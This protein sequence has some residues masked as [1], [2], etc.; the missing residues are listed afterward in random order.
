MGQ[1][2]GLIMGG[3]GAVIG[4]YFGG[5]MGAEAG[6]M[7][8]SMLGGILFP[9][10]KPNPADV[11]VQDS[12]Y[13]KYIPQVWGRYRVAGNMIWAGTPHAQNTSGKGGSS[14]TSGAYTKMSF[15][16]ALCEGPVD[17]VLRI[18]ANGKLIYDVSNPS[19]WQS[20]SGSSSMI[21]GWTFYSGGETQTADPIMES[22]LGVGNVPAFRGLCYVVFNELNLQQWGNY[23][24]SLSFEV[25]RDTTTQ[26]IV[27]GQQS[28]GTVVGII[29]NTVYGTQILGDGTSYGW[30]TGLD[31]YSNG[32][33]IRP[34]YLTSYGVQW[35]GPAFGVGLGAPCAG[36]CLSYD[37]PGLY[38][39]SGI[40]YANNGDVLYTGLQLG[41]FYSTGA[42]AVKRGG[43][44]YVTTSYGGAAYPLWIA[45][46]TPVKGGLA[47]YQSS[48][49]Q[50]CMSVIG[51]SDSYVYCA[52]A[53]FD[54]TAPN[55]IIYF[56]LTGDY[57]G[58][59][60]SGHGGLGT[61]A[62][63]VSDDEI[64]FQF[65]SGG[66]IQLWNGTSLTDIGIPQ[67]FGAN[68]CN[69]K[70]MNQ[71]VAMVSNYASGYAFAALLLGNI[72]DSPTLAEVVQEV[73][74]DA[75]L[76]T[77][78]FDVTQLT[79]AVVGY[80]STNN[81]S[82]RDILSPLLSTFFIDVSDSDGQLKFVRRGATPTVVIP[83]DDLGAAQEQ[84]GADA[85]NPIQE[86]ISQEV[87]LPA[88]EA[89]SYISST[90]DY[91]TSTQREFMPGTASN[92]I[93]STNVPVVLADN[94]AKVRVQ[95]MLWERWSKQRTFKF[96]TGYKYLAYE[97]G[98]V[99]L[100]QRN[101]L[102]TVP[103]RVTKTQFDGKGAMTWEA[104]FTVPQ[105]Y[106]NPSTQT[107]TAQGQSSTGFRQQS[108]DY[109][110]PTILVPM[111]LPPLRPQDA[112]TPAVYLAAGGFEDNWPGARIDISRDDQNFSDILNMSTASIIGQTTGILGTF[113]GGDIPDELNSINVQLY[114]AS[115]SLS[116]VSYASFLNGANVALIGTELV[117]FRNAVQQTDG[118]WTLSGL[119]RGRLDT[120]YNTTH[121]AG[122]VF[123]VL[124]EDAQQIV[125]LN[126][127]DVGNTIWLE[128]YLQNILGTTP[129]VPVSVKPTN[130]RLA[131]FRP[132]QLTALSGQYN[133]GG[134]ASDKT[135]AWFRRARINNGWYDGVDVPLDWQQESYK[136]VIST[137]AGVVVNTYT[138]AAAGVSWTGG[139][140]AGVTNP[141][142]N[143]VQ[144]GNAGISNGQTLP[145]FG[146]TPPFFI[147][148]STRRT[149]DG[150]FTGTTY[151]VSVSQIGDYGV[152]GHVSTTTF[153]Q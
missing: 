105:I 151:T 47:P 141:P 36:G 80:G 129:S 42:R 8:G 139:A 106:P 15:A 55:S 89:L 62:D 134:S 90:T 130:A 58:V 113:N 18:W 9:Q 131:P 19:D 52:T 143:N 73:C 88:Q 96:A 74:E 23:L 64:Y 33:A 32:Y 107:Y 81:S 70:M 53:S 72:N 109:S 16:V 112:T 65:N 40:W 138:L 98:D 46:M 41:L 4:G 29:N 95:A 44:M 97:P 34:Y 125:N 122:E 142:A 7:I 94:D 150:L 146:T 92:L 63:V 75:G 38:L 144:P 5:P 116:S 123:V 145:L 118:S 87:D 86:T 110:G 37:E 51:V 30:A 45:Q 102:T 84:D 13:G 137:S 12:A 127:S 6:F 101:D 148:T 149:A 85:L 114:D 21:T 10:K 78:Q 152:A 128:A 77:S 43:I 115:Q 71:Q 2:A 35:Q 120:L 93:E 147:Y 99:V 49:Q 22:Q 48:T 133:S 60:I 26:A 25:A 108:I 27:T 61:V 20:I 79:D 117:Y 66:N 28:I 76:T 140:Y 17:A 83:W 135:F 82:A 91:Q 24:P 57:M 119:L 69:L 103:V 11:R 59:L 14:K 39:A 126:L 100:L 124:D 111:D 31:P 121:A 54:A 3:V 50:F 1:A 68:C 132:A 67:S 136:I 153:T 104:D 56:D